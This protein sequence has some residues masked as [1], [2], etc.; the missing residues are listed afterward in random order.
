MSIDKFKRVTW[1]LQEMKSKDPFVYTTQQIRLA[2]M[3][4]IG[5]DE[6]T[7]TTTIKKMVELNILSKAEEMGKMKVKKEFQLHTPE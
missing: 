1:R 7:I 6:R 2:I 5:T 3:E 4:E